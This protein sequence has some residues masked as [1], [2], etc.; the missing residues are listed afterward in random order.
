V[1][2]ILPLPIFYAAGGDERLTIRIISGLLAVKFVLAIWRSLRERGEWGTRFVVQ[3]VLLLGIQLIAQLANVALESLALLMFGLL[4]W[5]TFPIQ[6][7]FAV[8]RDFQP[9]VEGE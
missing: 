6:L 9:P 2:A 3:A 8:I 7:L 5:L 4:A 1:V